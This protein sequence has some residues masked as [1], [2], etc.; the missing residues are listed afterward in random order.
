MLFRSGTLG[1]FNLA[2]SDEVQYFGGVRPG[3]WINVIPAGGI[4]L[5]PNGSTGCACNYLNESWF[6]LQPAR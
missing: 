2:D 3:C 1:Y 5:A 4:V 6:A